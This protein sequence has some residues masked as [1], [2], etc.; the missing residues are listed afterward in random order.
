MRSVV[1]FLAC[2]GFIVWAHS[3]DTRIVGVK[4]Y[5]HEPVPGPVYRPEPS[6]PDL[7]HAK[8]VLFA[9]YIRTVYLDTINVSAR[10][11]YPD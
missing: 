2:T 4:A 10:R 5:A 11:V 9:H 6:V 7:V 1:A 8:P 3:C